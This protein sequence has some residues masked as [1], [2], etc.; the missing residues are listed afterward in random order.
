MGAQDCVG[1][2]GL[3]DLGLLCNLE[4]GEAGQP[5][6]EA[7]QWPEWPWERF[8]SVSK[9]EKFLAFKDQPFAHG[10]VIRLEQIEES[11]CSPN[12]FEVSLD[13]AKFFIAEDGTNLSNF[14]PTTISSDNCIIAHI[15]ATTLL[16][17]L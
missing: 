14:D 16:P 10:R 13:E 4:V 7:S 5:Q 15:V 8:W 6:K 1:C 11:H 17:L 9:K 3:W 12:N 2:F